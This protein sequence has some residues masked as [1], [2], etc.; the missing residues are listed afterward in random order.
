MKH[1]IAVVTQVNSENLAIANLR[2]QGYDSYCPQILKTIRHARKVEQVKRP[3]FPGYVFVSLDLEADQWRA[4]LSTRGVRSIVQFGKRLGLLP[5]GFIESLISRED[6]GCLS[7]DK[8]SNPLSIGETVRVEN[9]A[10]N[11]LLGKVL[12]VDSKDRIWILLDMLKQG[13]KVAVLRE[14]LV[15]I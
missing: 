15:K 6:G 13:I 11:G 5:I 8:I 3:L 10:F 4:I 12:S 1:W 2:R 9:N 14:N 7:I